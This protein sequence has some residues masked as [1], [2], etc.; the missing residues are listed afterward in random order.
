[1]SLIQSI[2]TASSETWQ[3][4]CLHEVFQRQVA[5]TPNAVAIACGGLP[6]SYAEL[7]RNFSQLA[8]LREYGAVSGRRCLPVRTERSESGVLA[9]GPGLRHLHIGLQCGM[10]L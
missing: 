8:P 1:M 10:Q 5:E 2:Q 4:P 6:R 3:S 7:D 9:V